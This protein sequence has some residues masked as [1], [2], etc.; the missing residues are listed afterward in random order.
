MTPAARGCGGALPL[1]RRSSVL[2]LPLA[3]ALWTAVAVP[4]DGQAPGRVR[5]TL[6]GVYTD[7][8][9]DEG[10]Q[11]FTRICSKCH[12]QEN[13]L[14]GPSFFAKWTERPLYAIWE[15]LTTSMPYGAPASLAPEEYAAALAYILRLNGYPS[16]ET[17]LPHV[18]FEVANIDFDRPPRP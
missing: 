10:A 18:P 11:I 4:L 17:R 5:S 12:D 6:E 1:F 2:A 14:R 8:Q 3:A 15:F 7:A 9:A 13:P 16:G